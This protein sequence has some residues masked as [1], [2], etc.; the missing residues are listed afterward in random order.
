[1]N[2]RVVA[3]QEVVRTRNS[4]IVFDEGNFRALRAQVEAG[5]SFCA[6]LATGRSGV[7]A[8]NPSHAEV[9]NVVV[10]PVVGLCG[11]ADGLVTEAQAQ[12]GEGGLCVVSIPGECCEVIR[13]LDRRFDLHVK[14]L[15]RHAGPH[16]KRSHLKILWLLIHALDRPDGPHAKRLASLWKAWIG[17][18]K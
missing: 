9:M 15:A 5:T 3:E 1:M 16:I 6:P 8:T 14:T 2:G 12:F 13:I 18:S 7:S 10:N 17:Q 11:I 4:V